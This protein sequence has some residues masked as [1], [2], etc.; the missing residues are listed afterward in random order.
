[1]EEAIKTSMNGKSP[2]N[3]G[4][5]REFYI[6]FWKNISKELLESFNEGKNKGILSNSQR[7]AVIKLLEKKGKDKRL[8]ANWRPISL[9]NF[10]SKILTKCLAKRLKEVLPSIIECDQTAYVKNRFIGE[11]IRLIS[12]IL[13]STK[14][15]KIEGF[16]L[17]VDLE[18]A[19]DS[20]D[21]NF[22]IACLKK[23]NFDQEFVN[24]VRVLLNK[25]E[26]CVLNGGKSTG[27][28][29]LQRGVRQGDPISAYLFIIVIEILFLMV[30]KNPKINGIEIF[31]IKHLLTSYADDTSFF[32]KK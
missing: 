12:D 15:Q 18:K 14:K 13:D 17:T 21:H 11:S 7:Q 3:D 25:Q 5:N 23:M 10:D 20:V 30:R 1:M 32:C 16:L 9:I 2:G 8:I 28:F 29:P 26:S 27:Y 24:W 19:F 22:L 31:G 6:M 4:F